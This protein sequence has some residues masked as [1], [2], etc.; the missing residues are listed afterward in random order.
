M[1]LSDYHIHTVFCDGKNT[2]EEMVLAAVEKGVTAL[3]FSGHSYTF[4]D[5]SYCIKKEKIEAYR[6]EIHRLKEKYRDKIKILCGIEQDYY[7]EEPTAEYDYVIGSVHYIKCGENYLPMDEG[8]ERLKY[9]ANTFFGGDMYALAEE[10]YRTVGDLPNRMKPDIIGHFDLLTKYFEQEALLDTNSPRYIGA[11]KR[12]ADI[13]IQTGIPFEINTGAISR[14]CRTTPYPAKEIL[15]YL[16]EKKA[17][18]ILSSDSHA[19]RHI[20]FGFEQS[21]ALARSLNLTIKTEI[22][23]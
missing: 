7:S 22:N 18:V 17:P 16:A 3:G 9:A 1:I 4:F 6:D 21:E 5:E 10:Y 19:A 2:P 8:N 12:A 20:L 13:L 14:G 15:E 23:P 11:W